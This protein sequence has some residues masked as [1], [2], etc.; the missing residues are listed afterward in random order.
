MI[1]DS[2]CHLNYKGL[3]ERLDEVLENAK[4]NNISYM[5]TICTKISEFQT[6]NNIA[7]QHDNI[8]CSVGIH[9]NEVSDSE[10]L[11]A[12]EIIE[13]AK[14]DK[15]I[16]IG[17]TGLDYFYE[18]EK[19]ELQ[20]LS[21]LEHIK[22]AQIIELP[23]IIHSRDADNDMI[24]I[25]ETE[26]K[27]KKFPALLHCFSSGEELARRAIDI[28]IY[29]SLS[30]IVT[31][32]NATKLQEIA[33]TIPLDKLLVETDSPFLAPVPMRG[34]TNEP[35]YTKHVVDFLAELRETSPKLLAEKTT[36]NFFNLFKK[37]K[38]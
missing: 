36:D 20:R 2:H 32:K 38:R 33:K 22:A 19:A 5:Q 13:Y 12:E 14:G 4:Q 7:T 27:K 16:G 3:Q 17:E 18:K 35:A 1:V 26:M 10:F 15:V 11:K 24:E 21:F 37:A 9:P 31:F 34:K 8:F 23:L 28:G 6:I 29:V 25:L 30:G